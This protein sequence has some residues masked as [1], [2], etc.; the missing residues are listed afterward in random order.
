MLNLVQQSSQ[1]DTDGL[2][3]IVAELARVSF[4][5]APRVAST[6]RAPTAPAAACPS[7]ST[8][9][10][11]LPVPMDSTADVKN[12]ASCSVLHPT[13]QSHPTDDP[14][15]EHLKK[16]CLPQQAS[17]YATEAEVRSNHN[18]FVFASH[19]KRPLNFFATINLVPHE[20]WGQTERTLKKS[21]WD[22]L[23][24]IWR[25]HGFGKF[26]AVW[27]FENSEAGGRGLHMHVL[28]HIPEDRYQEFTNAF[29]STLSK[30]YRSNLESLVAR[31]ADDL[32]RFGIRL[33]RKASMPEVYGTLTNLRAQKLASMPTPK[34][35]A[36]LARRNET[37]GRL[38]LPFH[39]SDDCAHE[40]LSRLAALTK[41]R[42]MSKSIDPD[43]TTLHMG[44][45]T[46]I[47]AISTDGMPGNGVR[48]EKQSSKRFAQNNMGS[49]ANLKET[50]QAACPSFTPPNMPVG[51]WLDAK[52]YIRW[53]GVRVHET[54]KRLA[55]NL[56]KK[57]LREHMAAALSVVRA[58]DDQRRVMLQELDLVLDHAEPLPAPTSNIDNQIIVAAITSTRRR[59]EFRPTKI[60]VPDRRPPP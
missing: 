7:T 29:N 25:M 44:K 8:G 43:T 6:D 5:D 38:A 45:A 31:H 23:Y 20:D 1:T 51:E 28:A 42:Y 59:D 11:R 60:P 30:R 49:T 12:S 4:S 18:A 2:D 17:P 53:M 16:H 33:R 10:D 22:T 24:G 55:L 56:R 32:K 21:I 50:A 34:D 58:S 26:C 14:D 54:L 9:Y 57:N 37:L 48:L 41:L 36:A 13:D 15:Y 47:G 35:R 52:A 19:I 40:P 46:T 39:I 3:A 27:V